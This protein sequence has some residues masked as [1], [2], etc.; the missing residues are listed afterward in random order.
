MYNQ[1]IKTFI[2]V[3]D[4]GSFSKAAERLFITTVSVMKQINSLE[5]HIGVKLLKR[6]NQGVTLTKEGEYVY[7]TA[8]QIIEISDNTINKI[9]KDKKEETYTIKVGTSL[10][11]PAKPLIDLWNRVY[12]Q[13]IPVKIQIVPMEN[14]KTNILT[15]L[16]ELG[17]SIDC[18][19]APYE[20]EEVYKKCNILK[21][22]NYDFCC[23]V[24]RTHRLAK[25]KILK[26]KDLYNETLM[27]V[28]KGNSPAIDEIRTEIE[29]NHPKINIFDIDTFYGVDVFNECEQKDYIME[30]LS[31][32]NEIHPSLV[33]IPVEWNYSISYGIVYPKNLNKCLKT[34]INALQQNIKK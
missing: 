28:K 4:S 22:G 8:K 7:K 14:G 34:F 18:F 33:T 12:A 30:V 24:S 11:F 9:K 17:K 29:R 32:W 27:L 2:V 5:N 6:T 23:A 26:W 3:A 15:F 21:L 13:D 1:Q 25:N 16:S 10:L 19:V 20:A 31:S